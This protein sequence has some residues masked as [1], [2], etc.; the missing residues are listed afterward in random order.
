MKGDMCYM[1]LHVLSE[2]TYVIR[3]DM[4]DAAPGEG[5]RGDADVCQ[6]RLCRRLP[7]FRRLR[8]PDSA[9]AMHGR[10]EVDAGIHQV[11]A[12]VFRIITEY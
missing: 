10:R 3:G 12:Y 11:H 5:R 6:A 9:V 2:V 7:L 4:W 1:G 8:G